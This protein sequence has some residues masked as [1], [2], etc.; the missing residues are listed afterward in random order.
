MGKMPG[1]FR[2]AFLPLAIVPGLLRRV[3]RRRNRL[4]QK[5]VEL[6]DLSTLTRIARAALL[7]V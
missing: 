4:W 1:R 6:S 2:R 7:G 3:A 5:P